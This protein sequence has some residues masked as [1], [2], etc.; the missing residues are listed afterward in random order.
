[1]LRSCPEW[2]RAGRGRA[3]PVAG[4][5]GAETA[6]N[7]SEILVRN[8][9]RDE[10]RRRIGFFLE[11]IEITSQLLGKDSENSGGIGARAPGA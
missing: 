4:S 8:G 5:D 2:W 10:V 11:T 1:M 3:G 6:G 7:D 9:V